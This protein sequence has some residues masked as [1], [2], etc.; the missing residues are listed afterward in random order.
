MGTNYTGL[1]AEWNLENSTEMNSLIL[2]SVQQ[3]RSDV[4]NRKRFFIVLCFVQ[5]LLNLDSG[6]IP[7]CLKSVT[8]ELSMD[9]EEVNVHSPPLG[10]PTI[11][12]LYIVFRVD[13]GKCDGNETNTSPLL[14]IHRQELW[15]AFSSSV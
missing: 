3:E 10:F 11:R 2:E 6:I 7:A 1:R 15:A 13:C 8:D 14:D 12:F 9:P 5:I 4:G